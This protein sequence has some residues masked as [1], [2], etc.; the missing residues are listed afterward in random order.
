MQVT[1][2]KTQPIGNSRMRIVSKHRKRATIEE[3]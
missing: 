2:V 1:E 3:L